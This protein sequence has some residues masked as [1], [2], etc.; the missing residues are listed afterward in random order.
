MLSVSVFN[1]LN[2]L[3]VLQQQIDHVKNVNLVS[4]KIQHHI[5]ILRVKVALPRVT[6]APNLLLVLQQQID[7][8][9]NVDRDNIKIQVHI[10]RQP[11]LF[12]KKDSTPTKMVHLLVLNVL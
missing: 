6:A 8:V 3:L 1:L 10:P 2:I 11:V 4:I 5:Q 9:Q 12:A 7:H